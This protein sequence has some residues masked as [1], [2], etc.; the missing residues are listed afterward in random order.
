MRAS[1]IILIKTYRNIRKYLPSYVSEAIAKLIPT[2]FL[3]SVF[4]LLSLAIVF[5]VINVVLHPEFIKSNSI[6]LAIY[7][8]FSFTSNVQYVLFLFFVI[9]ICFLVKNIIVYIVLKKQADISY[10]IAKQISISQYKKY[11]NQSY[12]FHSKSKPSDLLTNISVIPFDF[13]AGVLLP[14]IAIINEFIL[15]I[16]IV[17]GIVCYD[18]YLLFSLVALTIPFLYLY[19]KIFKGK[20]DLV[21][22]NRNIGMKTMNQNALLSISGFREIVVF[23]KKTFF[24]PVFENS[25][26]RF[27][28]GNK[29]LY[30]LNTFSPKIIE[31]IA[32]ISILGIFIA[33][34][35]LGKD[36][37]SL[38]SFLVLFS[39]SAYRLIP[40][41]NRI[42]L[43]INNIKA[44]FYV[45]DYFNNDTAKE[46]LTLNDSLGSKFAIEFK[47]I[48]EI[49]DLDFS[50][51]NETVAILKRVN[52]KI[53]KGKTIGI[54]G[55]SGSGK[56][57]LLNILLRLHKE[58]SGGIFVDGV[59]IEDE[60]LNEWRKLI[61]YV[62][63]DI[64][65]IDGSIEENIAFGINKNDIN[66]S[67]IKEVIEKAQLNEFI[68]ELEFGLN[69][70]IGDG[71][72]NIS[73]GQRQRIAIAR[74]L[75]HGGK[76]L[77][78][79]EATS[80]LDNTTE[81]MLTESIRNISHTDVTIVIVAHRYQTLKYC[82][83]I[84]SLELGVLNPKPMT[85]IELIKG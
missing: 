75:Y 82:D 12:S 78:F 26:D 65:L 36:L 46:V 21:S 34:F 61:S 53:K 27:S 5:P 38:S 22:S 52:L 25:V 81:Q 8:Y 37:V 85:Y 74:A 4:E 3:L 68:N 73:G 18:F 24:T 57:T 13:V 20:L 69:T 32:I 16:M 50:F 15:I 44:S 63:Q 76:V 45:F 58:K 48:I 72:S 71:G 28:N 67:L 39:I 31:L 43:S 83:E 55:P 60:N 29:S 14:F 56:S 40:S 23:H 30:L 51:E 42:I 62:P 41:L 6:L 11:L 1:D 2:S 17:I 49:R 66:S 10:G 35:I 9:A 70:N 7:E 64:V 80:A 47:D 84:Y 59:K 54:V 33:G 19:I 79:D 77:L